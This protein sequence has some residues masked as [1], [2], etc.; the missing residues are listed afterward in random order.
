MC[1]V[2]A[3]EN[4]G[5]AICSAQPD[6]FHYSPFFEGWRISLELLCDGN[7]EN[8]SSLL[9]WKHLGIIGQVLIFK[10]FDI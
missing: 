5:I 4:F 10:S 3:S 7:R 6:L 8:V 1:K 2:A 9:Y